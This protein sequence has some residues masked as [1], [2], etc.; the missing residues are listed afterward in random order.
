MVE[1]YS[2]IQRNIS[3]D[4]KKIKKYSKLIS[5]GNDFALS[6]IKEII[7]SYEDN[8]TAINKARKSVKSAITKLGSVNI[9]K[10][11]NP[12]IIKAIGAHDVIIKEIGSVMNK[13]KNYMNKLVQVYNDAYNKSVEKLD[14]DFDYT[15]PELNKI[16]S[17]K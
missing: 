12:N 11:E 15:L 6:D 2:T 1:L 8:I 10:Q 16:I 7:N 3:M 14:E 5:D 4:F 13:R 9:S 17:N